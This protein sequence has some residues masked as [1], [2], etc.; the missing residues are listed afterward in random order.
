[1][2]I[3]AV[4]WRSG[5]DTVGIVAVGTPDEWKAYIGVAHG[6]DPED[7]AR[8]IASWG[9]KL[10]VEEAGAF[11]PYLPISGYEL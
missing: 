2:K 5:R 9:A 1:M 7:D 11:F 10:S 3:L 8:Y 4:E 6:L